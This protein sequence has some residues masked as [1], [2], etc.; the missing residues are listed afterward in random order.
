MSYHGNINVTKI[1]VKYNYIIPSISFPSLTTTPSQIH[2][3]FIF[4]C[5]VIYVHIYIIYTYMSDICVSISYIPHTDIE[6]QPV[7][8]I[9]CCL[10]VYNFL[11][12][13]L[14][15]DKQVRAIISRGRLFYSSQHHLV[16]CIYFSDLGSFDIS[17]FL[18]YH[19]CGCGDCSS[20]V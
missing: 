1:L 18:S 14:Y 2:V 3:L 13:H 10:Y 17:S 16:A 12:D 6:T 4:N 8:S 5:Y 20:S 9:Q 11:G 7:G 19:V 15:L